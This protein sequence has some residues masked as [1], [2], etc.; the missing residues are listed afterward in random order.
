MRPEQLLEAEEYWRKKVAAELLTIAENMTTVAI[1]ENNLDLALVA[2]GIA[3]GSEAALHP[4]LVKQAF[5]EAQMIMES[6]P[7]EV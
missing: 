5:A 4:E 6:E 1:Q 2:S 7:V 3:V